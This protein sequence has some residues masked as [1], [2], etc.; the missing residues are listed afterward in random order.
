MK[1]SSCGS[2]NYKKVEDDLVCQYCGNKTPVIK[3]NY[4]KSFLLAFIV[5]LIV[6]IG[7]F[8]K[9][10]NKIPAQAFQ[11]KETAPL[12]DNKKSSITINNTQGQ[13]GTQ[14]ITTDNNNIDINIDNSQAQINTQTIEQ[15]KKDSASQE[16]KDM[17]KTKK[18]MHK[19]GNM[20]E[21]VGGQSDGQELVDFYKNHKPN[22]KLLS[23]S[24]TK[25]SNDG[26]VLESFSHEYA[27]NIPNA[28]SSN[29]ASTN[30][31][32]VIDNKNKNYEKQKAYFHQEER[33]KFLNVETKH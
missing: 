7:L 20:I 31:G 24:Y 28:K 3:N 25:T 21:K 19:M 33:S 26:K 9:Q 4:S 1:C 13:I 30:N 32:Y 18:E 23:V 10:E 8:Q 5:V 11:M 17:L 6:A 16:Y 12:E 15:H 14:I 2:G 29:I 27:K 22:A